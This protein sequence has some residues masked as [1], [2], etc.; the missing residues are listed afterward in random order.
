MTAAPPQSIVPTLF[1]RIISGELPATILYRDERVIAF[2]DIHPRAPVHILIVTNKPIPTVND[3]QETDE[4][5]LGHLFIVARDL[6]RQEG[7]DANGYR[8]I[9]N[10]NRDSGQEV[11]HLHMHLVGGRPLGP[12]L[13]P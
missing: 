12:M 5:L 6:A 13:L 4:A 9:V 7:I 10:C 11:Y 3:V 1:E 8:L 2:R